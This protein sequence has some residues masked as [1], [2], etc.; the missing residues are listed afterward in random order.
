M[1]KLTWFKFV[2][3]DWMMGKIMKCPEITQARFL[4]LCCLYWNKECVLTVEDAEIEIDADH[5]QVLLSK[6]I[7][8]GDGEFINIKFLDE[9]NSDVISLSEKRRLA[10]QERWK[11][12]K[13]LQKSVVQNDTIVNKSD[14]IVLQSDTEENR[15]DKSR[16]DNKDICQVETK[17]VPT[18]AIDYTKFMQKFNSFAGRNFRV[19]KSVKSSLNA[20]LKDYSKNEILKAIEKA[21]KDQYHIDTNFKYLTPEF[22]LR[23]DKLE[24]FLNTPEK[25]INGYNPAH[26][27]LTN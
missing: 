4:R 1:E 17:V 18:S 19:T 2:I 9:Q 5:L 15:V 16:V 7:V 13:E 20:R 22:I 23:P 26:P 10:V 8:V 11:K 21:H 6:K 12:L 24:K 14:T 27:T 25:K 3:S